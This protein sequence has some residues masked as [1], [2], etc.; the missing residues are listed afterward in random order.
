MPANFPNN[1]A[2]N[3]VYTYGSQTWYWANNLGVW[4]SNSLINTQALQL[5]YTGNGTNT[6]FTVSGGY[7]GNNVQVYLNGVLLR[8]GTDYTAT[9]GSTVNI[10]P[11]PANGALIDVVGVTNYVTTGVSA[12][13]QQQFIANGSANSFTVTGGYL[14]NQVL[15]F[16]NGVKQVSGND[17]FTTSGNTVNFVKTPANNYI[18]DVYGQQ[19]G[20]T[21]SANA[22]SITGQLSSNTMSIGGVFYENSTTMTSDYTITTGRNAMSAGPITINTGVTI[23]VPSGSTWTVV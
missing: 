11:A 3:Q 21:L 13:V 22:F 5:Q 19:S 16:L 4:Q 6:V 1:P 10:T 18:I 12:I 7:Q 2:N 8:R 23:T 15:V 20:Y 17:V 14:P 9:D